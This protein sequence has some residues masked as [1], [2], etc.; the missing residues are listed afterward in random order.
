MA[1]AGF[2]AVS[3]DYTHGHAS[4]S[5]GYTLKTLA[6]I[7]SLSVLISC[8]VLATNQDGE[9]N[10]ASDKAAVS[11]CKSALALKKS[12]NAVYV[13]PIS[14]VRAGDGYEV[15]LSHNGEQWLCMTDG[16]NNVSQLEKRG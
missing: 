16:Y 7:A 2:H 14:H 15:F 9:N 8:P 5:E 1:T 11:A 12:V 6:F 3:P 4:Q 13:L 10:T